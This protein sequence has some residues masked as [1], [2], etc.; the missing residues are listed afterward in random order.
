[1]RGL[2]PGAVALA[3]ALVGAA[4]GGDLPVGA[5]SLRLDAGGTA[6]LHDLPRPLSRQCLDE[7]FAAIR[8]A[9]KAGRLLPL[10]VRLHSGHPLLLDLQRS[11]HVELREDSGATLYLPLR[12]RRLFSRDG[13]GNWRAW[14]L[15]A[16][17]SLL[18]CMDSG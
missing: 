7:G 16:E 6:V 5:E 15:P 18:P 11:P 4:C 1:M 12:G 9:R 2:R 10:R 14:E 8:E 17:L 3:S 13:E